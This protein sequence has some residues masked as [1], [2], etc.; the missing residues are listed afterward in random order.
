M[1]YEPDMLGGGDDICSDFF[2]VWSN[3]T[4]TLDIERLF[5][6]N[7]HLMTKGTLWVEHKP[8]WT[9][10]REYMIRTRIFRYD[11]NLIAR[12]LV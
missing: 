2:L 1:K 4:L 5:K 8:D 9:T 6:I 10:K 3:M 7:A 12:N 11:L